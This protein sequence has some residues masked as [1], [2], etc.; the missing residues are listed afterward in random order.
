MSVPFG[1][2][3]AITS[4]IYLVKVSGAW[5]SWAGSPLHIRTIP[6]ADTPSTEPLQHLC[7]PNSVLALSPFPL[8]F[9]LVPSPPRRAGVP[10]RLQRHRHRHRPSTINHRHPRAANNTPRQPPSPA[11]SG[12]LDLLRSHPA[13][14]RDSNSHLFRARWKPNHDI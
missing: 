14:Y 10:L 3:R 8:G 11:P 1:P 6:S 9:S 13:R 12:A 5:L 7:L 2:L 4:G